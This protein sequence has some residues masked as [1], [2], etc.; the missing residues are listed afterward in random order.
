MKNHYKALAASAVLYLCAFSFNEGLLTS[1]SLHLLNSHNSILLKCL[2]RALNVPG[3]RVLDGRVTDSLEG[4]ALQ[5]KTNY[6]DIFS[7]SW[8]PNDDGKTM[9]APHHYAAA[10]L[11]NGVKYVSHT[12]LSSEEYYMS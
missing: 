8:G 11:Q 4:E 3:I 10:A 2:L 9:E 7:A 1:Q 6:I 5:F 12:L